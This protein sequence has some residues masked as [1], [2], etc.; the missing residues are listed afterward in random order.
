MNSEADELRVSP[1]YL[2]GAWLPQGGRD[3]KAVMNLA[4]PDTL[5]HRSKYEGTA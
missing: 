5:R 1:D 3:E 4:V 2:R